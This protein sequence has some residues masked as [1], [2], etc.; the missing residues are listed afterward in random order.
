MFSDSRRK[1]N[2]YLVPHPHH[3]NPS[4]AEELD[5]TELELSLWTDLSRVQFCFAEPPSKC[6]VK[7][8]QFNSW[9]SIWTPWIMAW[10]IKHHDVLW[11]MPWFMVSKLKTM[12]WT[13]DSS[14]NIWRVVLRSKTGLDWDL[15]IN[16][17]LAQ[18][19]PVLLRRKD[20]YDEDGE[21][22]ISFSF[23]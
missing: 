3:T 16:S 22:D 23:F 4:S 21:Q 11:I 20:L 10:F 8:Q 15:F 5:S 13:V 6:F 2:W 19:S 17:A 12:N 1:K 9:F 7:S 14:R 18:S